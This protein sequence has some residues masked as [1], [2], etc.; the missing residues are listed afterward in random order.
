MVGPRGRVIASRGNPWVD[1]VNRGVYVIG[2]RVRF[3]VAICATEANIN[4][5][6]SP[7]TQTIRGPRKTIVPWVAGYAVANSFRKGSDDDSGVDTFNQRGRPTPLA[8]DVAV[9]C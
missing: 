6:Y 3:P 9:I 4:L 5:L 7:S 8:F 2:W 1:E